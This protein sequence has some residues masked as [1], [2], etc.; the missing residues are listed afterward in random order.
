MPTDNYDLTQAELAAY[1]HIYAGA[2]NKTHDMIK[3]K[4]GFLC[5]RCVRTTRDVVSSVRNS[6]AI[7]PETE[8][9]ATES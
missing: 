2:H 4:E 6:L 5:N 7:D 3:L 9:N 8:S 1:T